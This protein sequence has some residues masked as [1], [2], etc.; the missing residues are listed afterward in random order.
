MPDL[1]VVKAEVRAHESEFRLE[2][3]K[4]FRA[5][6]AD[7]ASETANLAGKT[8]TV[9]FISQTDYEAFVLRRNEPCVLEAYD[10]VRSVG[11]NPLAE[12]V[13]GG[14]DANWLFQ[15]GI[16]TVSL[17]AGQVNAHTLE[18]AVDIPQFI[19]ACKIALTIATN[20]VNQH[21]ETRHV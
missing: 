14:T 20:K 3:V 15:H 11:L 13:D 2:V 4:A 8:A 16:P 17:G 9:D 21:K 12:V 19:N 1:V 6:F 5:A 7:A 10:A 18:E